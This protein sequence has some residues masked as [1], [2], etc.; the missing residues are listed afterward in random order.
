MRVPRARCHVILCCF[1]FFLFFVLR[2]GRLLDRETRSFDEV[3]GTGQLRLGPAQFLGK[4]A[5]GWP[6]PSPLI[7]LECAALQHMFSVLQG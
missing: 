6:D 1:L 4:S 3:R 7:R 5:F 2:A